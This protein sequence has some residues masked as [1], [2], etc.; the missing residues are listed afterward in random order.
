V[1]I[2]VYQF[3]PFEPG[4]QVLAQP[5]QVR[6]V[7]DHNALIN[8]LGQMGNNRPGR[9]QPRKAIR[10]SFGQ[11]NG[12]CSSQPGQEVGQSRQGTHGISIWIGMGSQ[13]KMPGALPQITYLQ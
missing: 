11:E 13:K 12:S 10:Q 5:I 2:N 7:Q 1:V 4:S 9:S 3:M 6:T 8:L